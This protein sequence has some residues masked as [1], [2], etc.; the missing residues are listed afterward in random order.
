MSAISLLDTEKQA[1]PEYYYIHEVEYVSVGEDKNDKPIAVVEIIMAAMPPPIC[2][3][4][5]S[6]EAIFK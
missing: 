2:T 3:G 6:A 5:R 4:W 1:L